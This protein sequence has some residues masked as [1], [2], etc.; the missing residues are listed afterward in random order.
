M[1]TS[2]QEFI[3]KEFN[4]NSRVW[5]YQSERAF[6]QDE[7]LAV[8][9]RL[10]EF[11]QQWQSHGSAVNNYANLFFDRFIIL[12]ADE[13]NVTVGGCST[14]SSTRFIKQLEKD[15]STS[16]FN[17]QLLAFI[18][19]ERIE[20]IPIKM[21]NQQIEQGIITGD[22]LYF[23]NTILTKKALLQNWII[24]VKNSWLSARIPKFKPI[25][26]V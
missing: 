2:F 12:M 1:N 9:E 4:D 3:P 7:A 10:K 21:V 22:T 14:D 13:S 20:T 6:S 18:I 26:K 16:L 11:S 15:Y 25:P 8:I 24:P 23:N 5:I 17:R 19:D